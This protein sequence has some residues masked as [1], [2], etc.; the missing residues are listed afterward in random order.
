M[1]LKD[2]SKDKYLDLLGYIA[3]NGEG[4]IKNI[5]QKHLDWA[6][7][8]ADRFDSCL[9]AEMDGVKQK[10]QGCLCKRKFAF[11]RP[12][13]KDPNEC[14]TVT[15]LEFNTL[16]EHM[17]I[18][19]SELEMIANYVNVIGK[20]IS[21][22][23]SMEEFNFTTIL[24]RSYKSE[25]EICTCS[26]DKCNKNRDAFR[27]T[28]TTATKLAKTTTKGDDDDDDN[29]GCDDYYCQYTRTT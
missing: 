16:I 10:H 24:K 18:I 14:K 23:N 15:N 4:R 17:N 26:Q 20:R 25:I 13:I 19:N 12:L 27:T 29:D 3:R 11:F 9:Y 8:C 1:L 2:C 22:E 5:A 28:T 21:K 7:E 6:N